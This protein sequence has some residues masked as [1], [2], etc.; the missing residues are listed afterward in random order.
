[1][2][3]PIRKT[4]SKMLQCDIDETGVQVNVH[5]GGSFEEVAVNIAQV[6]RVVYDQIKNANEEAGQYF[7]EG[8]LNMINDERIWKTESLR[9]NGEAA[10]S[11]IFVDKPT[12]ESK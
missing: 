5:A 12:E 10:A 2:S 11:V 3:A 4:V 9:H 6:I 8:F 7:K 1:M